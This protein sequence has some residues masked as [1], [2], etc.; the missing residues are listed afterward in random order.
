MS[1]LSNDSWG[2]RRN[3]GTWSGNPAASAWTTIT[4]TTRHGFTS[5]EMLDNLNLT[6]MNGRVYDQLIGRFLSADPIVQAPDFTQSFNRYSYTFNNPLNAIDPSGFTSITSEHPSIRPTDPNYRSYSF[7]SSSSSS[8]NPLDPN[9]VEAHAPTGPLDFGANASVGAGGLMG[10]GPAAQPWPDRID[11]MRDT[12]IN[13]QPAAPQPMAPMRDAPPDATQP[14][15]GYGLSTVSGFGSGFV[16]GGPGNIS[17]YLCDKMGDCGPQPYVAPRDQLIGTAA[18]GAIVVG[19]L[20]LPEVLGL[21]TVAAAGAEPP[22]MLG[23]GSAGLES[24]AA[25]LGARHL[26]GMG[27]GWRAAFLKAIQNPAQKIIVS[28]DG[29]VGSSTGQMLTS[30]ARYGATPGASPFQWEIYQLFLTGR[31]GTV[32]LILGGQTVPNPLAP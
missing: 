7:V 24:T 22:L 13:T 19:G 4:N 1:R 10:G 27:E 31:L 9:G 14:R 21:G 16:H 18:A 30:L 6:H 32:T 25:R 29:V 3:G 28:L 8:N 12:P 17:P 11:Q 2:R 15:P 5:H 23:I 26:M 20:F